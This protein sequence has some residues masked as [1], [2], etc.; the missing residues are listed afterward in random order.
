MP[1][2]MFDACD[3]GKALVVVLFDSVRRLVVYR[4]AVKDVQL[5]QLLYVLLQHEIRSIDEN[6]RQMKYNCK[7]G[8]STP[9]R[10]RI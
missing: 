10:R 2:S 3:V 5:G 7:L 8:L 4:V 1:Y 9:R 6:S